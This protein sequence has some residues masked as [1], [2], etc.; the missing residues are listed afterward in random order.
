MNARPVISAD[1]HILPKHNPYDEYQQNRAPGK[2][3]FDG[4]L[5]RKD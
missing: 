2:M 3:T 4:K 5:Q 1:K